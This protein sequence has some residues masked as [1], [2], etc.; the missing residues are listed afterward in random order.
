M[1]KIG[2]SFDDFNLVPIYSEIKSRK[3]PDVSTNVGEWNYKIPIISSPMNTITEE[4]MVET[5]ISIGGCSVLH[6]YMSIENQVKM[7][8][9]IF[10]NNQWDIRYPFYVAVGV[11]GDYLDRVG[12]LFDVGVRNFCIDVANGHSEICLKSVSNIIDKYHHKVDPLN[13]MA[14][15]VC[16]Y[17]GAY[18][19][20]DIGASSIRVG[21]GSGA[22][23]KTR[24][25]TGFGVP[26][27]T[28]VQDCARIKERFKNVSIISDGGHRTSGDMV[29][30]LAAGA[31]AIMVGG[32]LAGSSETPGEVFKD[33]DGNMC[34]YYKGMASTEGRGEWF[35]KEMSSYVPEGASFKVPYKGSTKRIIEE[36][37]GGIKVGMSFCNAKNLEELRVNAQW[38]RITDNGRREGN[39][40]SKMFKG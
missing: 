10:E 1:T 36:L 31:D 9:Y 30:S 33:E 5:L 29:K 12:V 17:D 24:Q 38:I 11:S 34:K 22:A 35:D 27:L 26:Q 28:A 8:N 23:C 18:R 20:A 6:R 4:Y 3:E 39:P 16:T 2:Y 25:V 13:I 37:V 15:N 7:C 19:L 40:N 14:G 32:L 21:V